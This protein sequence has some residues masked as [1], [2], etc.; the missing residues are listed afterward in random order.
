MSGVSAAMPQLTIEQAFQIAVRHHQAGQLPQAETLYREILSRQPAHVGALHYLGVI[1]HQSGR[2]DIA[3]D[4]VRKAL[5]LNPNDSEIHNNLGN[6]LKEAGQLDQAIA[7]CRHAIL[8]NPNLAEAYNN[9]GNALRASGQF[10]QAVVAFRQAMVLKPN[11]PDVYNN[12]GNVLADMGE[13]DESI[14]AYRQAIA[15]RSNYA[16]AQSNL[17]NAMHYHPGYNAGAIAQELD[18]WNRRYAEQF[19]QF[20]QP[21]LNDRNPQRRL[22]IG[23][24]SSD[25]RGHP[26]GRF[27]LPLLAHHDKTNFQVFAYSQ[28]SVADAITRQLRSHVDEWRTIVNLSDAQA[29]DLIRQDRI[30]IL[31]D[32]T[33]HTIGNRLLVFAR[34][35]APVQVTYLAFC[36]TTGLQAIDYRLSD[37]YLDPPGEDESVYS[38][39]TIRLPETYWCYQP[40]LDNSEIGPSPTLDRGFITFGSLNS[41]CKVTEP[42]LVTWAR[43]LTAVP[44]SQ[45]LLHAYEGAHR[46]GVLDR[47]ER[48]N[49]DP[50]RVRF[51]G[52][53]QARNYF[54]LYQQIDV[55]L[56]TFPFAGGTTTCDALWMGVPVV[57]LAGKTAVGR[58]GS[59]ILS[60]LGMPE[61]IAHT[62]EEYV[63]I[64]TEL[65]QNFPRLC[66]LHSVLRHR[67]EQSPLMDA[68]RFARNIES[69]Y[70][71]MWQ[72]YCSS[73]SDFPKFI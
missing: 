21:H 47:L 46:Q 48:E 10:D 27:M 64:A 20:T 52:Y 15:L 18:I 51:A 28:T 62:E 12:L 44:K 34:K 17:V 40:I 50:K 9:L 73:S 54:E 24:V 23:Y 67:M 2:S 61:L 53:M 22:R 37:P 63:Q 14:A 25:F 65:A 49:V 35:P 57:S 41:F 72:A 42:A 36:S 8:L 5:S 58:G 19:K 69:A 33:M 26:V 11:Y 4:L 55:A 45:L 13:L 59:S 16:A 66:N 1:A 71:Q 7:A 68:P 31:V 6:I 38:E 39:K 70:R 32:L 43:I 60:N 30:D 29:A 56:D 3:I